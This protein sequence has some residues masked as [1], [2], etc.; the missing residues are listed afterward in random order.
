M[1]GTP[2]SPKNFVR[3]TQIVI[4]NHKVDSRMWLHI[5]TLP[6]RESFIVLQQS[7]FLDILE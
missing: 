5:T 7:K 2:R 4:N 1:D 3:A 6:T